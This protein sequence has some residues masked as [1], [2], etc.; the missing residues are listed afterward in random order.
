MSYPNDPPFPG[1]ADPL[2]GRDPEEV[3][4]HK[5]GAAE[6]STTDVVEGQAGE[7]AGTA[8]NAGQHVAGVAAEQ[9]GQVASEATQQSKKLVHQTHTD[10]VPSEDRFISPTPQVAHTQA[11]DINPQAHAP[12]PRPPSPPTPGDEP[13]GDE[14]APGCQ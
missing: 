2:S 7:V 3:P 9:A 5:A 13:S 11:Y 6:P 12:N 14:P 4:Q 1:G 8:R 10:S